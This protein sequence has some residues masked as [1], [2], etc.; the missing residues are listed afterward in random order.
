MV[1]SADYHN[2]SIAGQV[3]VSTSRRQPRSTIKPLIYAAA[4][5][6][7]LIDAQSILEDEPITYQLPNGQTY[8]PQNYDKKYHGSMTVRTA[9][10]NSFNIPAVK[11]LDAYGVKEI[12]PQLRAMGLRPQPGSR[13]LVLRTELGLGQQRGNALGTQWWISHAGQFWTLSGTADHS[14][15]Y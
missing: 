4:I 1:G 15:N 8:S 2:D 12:V 11:V 13:R 14:D 7:K 5:D 3:N 6:A 10:A 9:L